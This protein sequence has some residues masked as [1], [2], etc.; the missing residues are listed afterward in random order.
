MEMAPMEKMEM[1]GDQFSEYHCTAEWHITRMKSEYALAVYNFALKI[2][3]RSGRFFCSALS[4]AEYFDC[5]EK[6]IRRARKELLKAG[7]LKLSNQ[8]CFEPNVYEPVSH[9]SWAEK[10]P[11]QCVTRLEFSWS[12]EGNRLGR[13]LWTVSAGK[14]PFKDYQVKYL[15]KLGYTDEEVISEFEAFWRRE[16]Q[17]MRADQFKSNRRL[18]IG[19]FI[20]FMKEKAGIS[21]VAV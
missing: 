18:L 19:R 3:K 15:T 6:T 2:S 14:A 13:A 1:Q 20:N 8:A 5:D 17:A 21:C 4:L 16:S 12:H 7:F 10:H 9:K 11:G